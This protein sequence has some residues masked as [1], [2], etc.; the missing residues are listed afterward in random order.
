M[1]IEK[2]MKKLLTICHNIEK[3]IEIMISIDMSEKTLIAS[4]HLF[5]VHSFEGIFN[6]SSVAFVCVLRT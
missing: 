6:V 1:I 3:N 5:Q 2:L 4:L